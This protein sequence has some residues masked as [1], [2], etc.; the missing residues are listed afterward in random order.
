MVKMNRK[1]NPQNVLGN[2]LECEECGATYR[3]RT[4]RGKGVYWCASRIEKGREACKQS[5]TVGEEWIKM[6]IGRR[7]CGGE[8]DENIIR[9][10][11]VRVLVGKDGKLKILFRD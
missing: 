7:V 8:Y 9:K 3:R 5:P 2:I 11:V 10:K 1:Y 4:E 6:E